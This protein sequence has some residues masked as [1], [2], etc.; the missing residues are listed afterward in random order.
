MRDHPP[1]E[2]KCTVDDAARLLGVSKSWLNRLRVVG[3]GP[4]FVKLG[5]RVVYDPADLQ[6][7]AAQNKRSNTAQYARG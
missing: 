6:A 2:A 4:L 5:R 3:G 7:W 1:I